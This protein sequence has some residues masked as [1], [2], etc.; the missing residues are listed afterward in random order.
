VRLRAN[1]ILLPILLT[2]YL[3]GYYVWLLYWQAEEDILVFGGNIFSVIAPLISSVLLF[4]AYRRVTGQ[5]RT[6]WLLLSVGAMSYV[7]AEGLWIYYELIL[8]QTVPF[9]SWADFFYFMQA[10]CFVSA[11]LHKLYTKKNSY[12]LIRLLFD[13]MIVMTVA[14]S[15]SWYFII[16]P[17]LAQHEITTWALLISLGY[18]LSDLVLLLSAI[19]MY[20]SSKEILPGKIFALLVSGFLIQVY[21]DTVYLYLTSTETYASGSL[22]DPL[23]VAALL[24]TGLAGYYVKETE[25]D[26]ATEST[27]NSQGPESFD[28]ARLLLPYVSV[29]LLF[30]MNL[31]SIEF[32]SLFIGTSVAILLLIIRQIVA[33]VENNSLL[34][35]LHALNDVLEQKVAKRTHELS[36][37]NTQLVEA[38][39]RMEHMAYH[40]ALTNLPNRRFFE[41]RLSAA[42][43]EARVRNNIV[44]VLFLDLDRFKNV[45]DYL[46]HAV[47]DLLLQHV[48][49]RLSTCLQKSDVVSRQGGDEFTIILEH[50]TIEEI[51]KLAATIRDEL[52]QPFFLAGNE[53]RISMSM[54]IGVYPYDG[55]NAVTLMKN[56]DTALYLAKERGKNNFQFFTSELNERIARKMM[57]E[58]ALHHALENNEFV[59]H[60]QPQLNLETGKITGVEALI[61]W[62]HPEHGLIPPTDFIPLAE[63]TGLI[64]P[65]G[66]WMLVQAC[67]QNQHWQDQGFPPLKMGI[68]LSARQF[69]QENLTEKV[70]HAL[71]L[72][73]L[74]PQYLDLEITESIA[75][76][77]VE[78]VIDKLRDL[79]QLGVKIS[80]DDFGTGYSSLSYLKKFPL[81][82]LKI[83]QPFVDDIAT[84]A[85]DLAIVN[86]IIVMARSMK[87]NVIAEGVETPVQLELLR[88]LQCDEVQGYLISKPVPAADVEAL[89]T[90]S[91]PHPTAR[92]RTIPSPMS[93]DR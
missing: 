57:L 17:I 9:P 58:T 52:H 41:M 72:T 50:R 53:L 83:A 79:K 25:Y 46:G 76:Q 55:D 2:F 3:A 54:G 10:L 21:A 26:T 59:V 62:H 78:H 5:D 73:G 29:T 71:N 32:N 82:T 86:A 81:H 91:P 66:E 28:Y 80:I 64:V 69:M 34:H 43:A 31:Q 44:A 19:S 63:E 90:P 77:N 16:Q 24:L 89:L 60:Y 39:K 38:Y 1:R 33:I 8:Q 12:H 13:T 51:S 56:A 45:N 30:I 37:K 68:N 42:I 27:F 4:N 35:R 7:L 85:E 40:D 36:E 14:V 61:R 48:S 70:A 84:N 20:L 6:F 87:L 93:T 18:P 11:F 22:Y 75:M 47:G 65:I 74:D 67:R 15:F 92:H 49:G 88:E 23:W